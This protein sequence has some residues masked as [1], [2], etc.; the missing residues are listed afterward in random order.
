M[1]K[2]LVKQIPKSSLKWD[3][4]LRDVLYRLFIEKTDRKTQSLKITSRALE[5]QQ[6]KNDRGNLLLGPSI[7]LEYI[8]GLQIIEST[9][10]KTKET[11]Q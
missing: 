3:V 5:Q 9:N 7:P 4:P 11:F 8:L 6:K 1:V 10:K 2:L